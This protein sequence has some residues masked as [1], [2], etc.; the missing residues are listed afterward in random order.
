M[1]RMLAMDFLYP[2]APG[3]VTFPDNHDMDRIFTQLNEDYELWRMAMAYFATMRGIP[4]YYYGTE[5]LMDSTEDHSHGYIR[6][7][8][9]GG[10]AGDTRN[11]YTGEGMTERELEAQAYLRT[12]LTWRRDKAVIH[13]GKTM[14][15]VPEDGTYVYF[16]YDDS[17]SVMVVINKNRETVPLALERFT[18]RLEGYRSA[19][20]VTTGEA[21]ELGDSISLPPR[22]VLVLDLER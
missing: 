18:E 7:D 11:A 14:H 2:D 5:I 17:D 9:P 13:N 4:Q 1:Y 19:T 16:R 21:V 6:S 22:S 3:L 10:W 12:L 8:F 15:F 20:E